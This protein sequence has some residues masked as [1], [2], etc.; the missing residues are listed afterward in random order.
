MELRSAF[1][2]KKLS[3]GDPAQRYASQRKRRE[4]DHVSPTHM[5]LHERAVDEIRA[6]KRGLR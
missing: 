5:T 2:V 4:V 6:A 1:K 3:D